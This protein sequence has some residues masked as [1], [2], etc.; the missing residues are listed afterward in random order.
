M[1]HVVFCV[2]FT[3][4]IYIKRRNYVVVFSGGHFGCHLKY[5]IILQLARIY[6]LQYPYNF[7][8]RFDQTANKHSNKHSLSDQCN[9]LCSWRSVSGRHF[10]CHLEFL[11]RFKDA[12][13]SLF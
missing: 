11:K 5:M 3:T 2:Y 10:G 1:N 6:K 9:E 4:I 8:S 12:T 7:L 13:S